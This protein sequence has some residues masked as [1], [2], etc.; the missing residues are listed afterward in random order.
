E[1][2]PFSFRVSACRV[3][4]IDSKRVADHEACART[5]QPKN[6][7]SDL[8]RSAKPPHRLVSH[9]IFHGERFL[10]DHVC[11]H[12]RLD[13]SRAHGID[14]N[15]SGGIFER[16]TLRQTDHSMLGC[17]VYCS[18]GEADQATNGRAVDD[19]TASAKALAVA[20][21]MPEPAPV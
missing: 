13:G 20:R 5:A 10:G 17:M 21:P 8:L 18:A 3:S 6:G 1:L 16:R 4:A 7:S 9:H 12:W 15:A 14:A 19:G 11:N 2:R